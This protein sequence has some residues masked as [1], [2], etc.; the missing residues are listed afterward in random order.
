MVRLNKTLP[1]LCFAAAIGFVGYASVHNSS[2]PK[3]V[4]IDPYF[5]GTLTAD[6]CLV[7]F[8]KK[9]GVDV[10]VSHVRYQNPKVLCVDSDPDL[11]DAILS[12]YG[13]EEE[14]RPQVPRL[15]PKMKNL[16]TTIS[17][18]QKEFGYW[19]NEEQLLTTKR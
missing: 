3:T 6:D 11:A 12:F 5:E 16:L 1:Y 18:A 13:I 19:L 10:V 15:T 7:D 9:P 4:R 17:D 8:D 14:F 2:Q